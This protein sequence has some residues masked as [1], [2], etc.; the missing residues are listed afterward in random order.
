M[1]VS[2][3]QQTARS[4]T[5]TTTAAPKAT[6]ASATRTFTDALAALA[7]NVGISSSDVSNFFA[8][9][10]SA[11]KIADTASSLGLTKDQVTQFLDFAAYGGT[12]HTARASAVDS[13]LAQHADT[14]AT[15]AQGKLSA[16]TGK[17]QAAATNSE[18]AM[19]AAADI[20]AFYASRPTENQETAKAKALGLNAAQFVQF[21]VIGNGLDVQK[22]SAPVLETMF[23]DSANRLGQDIG[24]GTHGGWTSYFAPNLGRAVTKEEISNFFATNPSQAQ[25]FQKASELGLS[26]SAINN[27]MVGVGLTKAQDA[28]KAYAAMNFAL[29]KGTDGYSMDTYGHIVTGGG[30]ISVDNGDSSSTWVPYTG[31]RPTTA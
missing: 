6:A 24:G 2:N 25:I 28:N 14:Y 12:D 11:E 15:D 23:V 4:S 22:I 29:Y 17:A 16:L 1:T 13:F 31:A 9:A 7:S 3:I 10:P 5:P 26:A 18:K 27:M 19:P 20:K 21:R 30:H 8:Q